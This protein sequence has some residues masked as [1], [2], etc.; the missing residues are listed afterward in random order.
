MTNQEYY[1][2]CRA[3]SDVCASKFKAIRD[4][5]EEDPQLNA[6]GAYEKYWELHN[7][8]TT[9]SLQWGEFCTNNKPSR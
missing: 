3:F 4:L 1:D 2:R 9:A 5:L 7:A 8:A 6:D